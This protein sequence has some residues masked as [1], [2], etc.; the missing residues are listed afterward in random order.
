MTANE[1]VQERLIRLTLG[2]FLIF[3]G[4]TDG[5]SSIWSILMGVIGLI[6]AVTGAVGFC[7]LYKVI[8]FSTCKK[9]T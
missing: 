8:G 9:E 2:L 3:L 4:V 7:P 5:Y 1:G 6:L